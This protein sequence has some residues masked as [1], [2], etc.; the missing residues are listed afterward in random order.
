M[1]GVALARRGEAREALELMGKASKS[2][3]FLKT[4]VLTIR[5]CLDEVTLKTLRREAEKGGHGSDLSLVSKLLEL[6]ATTD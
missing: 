6:A 5:T 1:L 4:Q 2:E 3:A